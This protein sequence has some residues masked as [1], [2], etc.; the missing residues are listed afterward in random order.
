MRRFFASLLL[1]GC[2]SAGSAWAKDY[3]QDIQF[4]HKQPAVT[5]EGAVVRT[6][7]DIYLLNA[8]KGHRLSVNFSSLENNGALEVSPLING[9]PIGG[10]VEQTPEGFVWCG[11]LPVSGAYQIIISPTRGNVNYRAEITVFE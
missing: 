3:I 8:Q 4:S 9:Q 10:S 2:L 1:I 6:D 11:I 5:V 7:R